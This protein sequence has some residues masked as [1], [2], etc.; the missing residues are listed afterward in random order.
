M[1]EFPRD[2]KIAFAPVPRLAAQEADM[3]K[4]GGLGDFIAINS[5]SKNK[6][7]AW[8]F[9]KWYAD[10]GMMPMAAGGR[11]PSSNAVDQQTAID[12]VFAQKSSGLWPLSGTISQASWR[13]DLYQGQH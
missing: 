10:G 11:L 2:W 5:K 13:N 3:V 4:S 8:E 1:T 6:E 9:L 12:F 7:A